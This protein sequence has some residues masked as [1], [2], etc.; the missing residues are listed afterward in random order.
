VAS[1]GLSLADVLLEGAGHRLLLL[2]FVVGAAAVWIQGHWQGDELLAI[3]PDQGFI[4]AMSR[5]PAVGADAA[6]HAYV[7]QRT[8][9]LRPAG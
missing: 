1:A 9:M 7:R 3:V 8:D 6:V 2:S 5:G 4:A